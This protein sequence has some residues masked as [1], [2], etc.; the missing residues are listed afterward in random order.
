MGRKK[1]NLSKSKPL[2]NWRALNLFI[3]TASEAACTD[4][5]KQEQAGKRRTVFITR[6]HSRLNRVRR[7]REVAGLMK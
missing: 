4:L 3:V 1:I 2:D 7:V 5:L 6:I